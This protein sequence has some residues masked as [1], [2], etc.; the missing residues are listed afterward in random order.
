MTAKPSGVARVATAL[1]A[2]MLTLP[3]L[4]ALAQDAGAK[5]PPSAVPTAAPAGSAIGATMERLKGVWVE[6][7]GF[8]IT[9]GK[10]Y[11]ACS[12]RCLATPKC[13]MIEFY[14]PEKKCN[15]YD[16]VRPRLP[17]GSSDVAI[18]R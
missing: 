9:Y 8:D 14:R 7:P 2:V 1:L 12:Q 15:M 5:A 4:S 13:A 6:G 11:A 10:D 16:T 3:C 17:G 18:R